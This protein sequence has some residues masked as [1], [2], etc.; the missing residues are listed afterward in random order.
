MDTNPFAVEL[1]RVTLMI[2]RKIAIDNLQL[3][4]PAL[5]LDT[6]DNNIVCQDALFREWPK[7]NAIIGNPPFL[8][9]KKLRI[10]LGDEYAEKLYKAF[11]DVKGQPDFCVFWFRK[12]ADLLKVEQD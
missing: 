5:P 9:G 1:A 10:E 4:E 12:A 6:L 7:A 8:G 3:T 11:P 2:A